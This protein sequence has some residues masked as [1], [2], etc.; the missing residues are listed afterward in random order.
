MDL[1]VL[2]DVDVHLA[3]HAELGQV[4]P[5]LDAE[6]GPRDDAAVV[7]GFQAVDVRA[8]AVDFLADV[9]PGAVRE[10]SPY[11]AFSITA[12]VASSTSQPR[13]RLA[14]RRRRPSPS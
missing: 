7:A 6:A 5:R 10:L 9:V 13:E 1:A 3:A 4:D 11:P 8:V 2:V 14:R 12:R